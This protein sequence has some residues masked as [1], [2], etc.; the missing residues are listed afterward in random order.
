MNR[1]STTPTR[2]LIRYAIFS[3]TG[4]PRRVNCFAPLREYRHKES[5]P[6][7]QQ[8]IAKFAETE[9]RADN[10]TIDNL[11]SHPQSCPAVSWDDSVKCEKCFLFFRQR[12]LGH[13]REIASCQH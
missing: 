6:R 3:Q 4:P 9:P 5:F 11:R 12:V 1:L 10:L 13:L 7:T 2:S 8:N